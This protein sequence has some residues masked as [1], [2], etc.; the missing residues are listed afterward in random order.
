VAGTKPTTEA[1]R[2]RGRFGWGLWVLVG[3]AAALGAFLFA[4]EQARG[5]GEA[6]APPARGLPATPD[7]HALFVFPDDPERLLLGTHVGIYESLD[8]GVRWRFLGLEGQDAM[9]FAHE[10]D[11]T[12]WVAGHNVLARSEDGAKTWRNAR[13]TGLPSLDVHG[14]AV[15]P[16]T[17]TVFAAV[18]GEG[19]YRSDD[20][21]ETFS[22]VPGDVG[23]NVYAL[24]VTHDGVLF[25]AD[26]KRG[27]LVS[28]SGDGVTWEQGGA[29]RA[30]GLAANE[31]EPPEQRVLAAGEEV[32]LFT[33]AGGWSEVFRVGDGS[34][35]VAF[36]A[37]PL[38]AY[39]VG[40]DRKL[41]RS[42]DAGETWAPVE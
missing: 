29:M 19:L 34:G 32:H 39:L 15:A 20:G 26:S 38:V 14:F 5:G 33:D 22:E 36:A 13:P 16:E 2:G 25:A 35:P 31:G 6:V 21:G 28:R 8:G 9:H 24:A 10:E 11:G 1:D 41:Y 12:I 40:F 42:D 7:Y 23:G 18:A 17:Q 37:D 30:A 4:R 27:V 3:I